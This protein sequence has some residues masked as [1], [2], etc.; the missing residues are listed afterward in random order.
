MRESGKV[1]EKSKGC[2]RN[3][4]LNNESTLGKLKIEV[5]NGEQ[6]GEGAM[7]KVEEARRLMIMSF[8]LCSLHHSQ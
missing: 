2:P 5:L 3:A 8:L 7:K 4:E 1:E 6:G